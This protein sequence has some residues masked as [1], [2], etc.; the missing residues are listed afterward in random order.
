MTHTKQ[1]IPS[2]SNKTGQTL[3]IP[4]LSL[5]LMVGI[6]GSGKSTFAQQ[7]FESYEVVSSDQCRGIVSNNE[8]DLNATSDAF[9]LL[10]YTVS[11]RLKNGLLTVVDATNVQ[12]ESRSKLVRLAKEHHVLPV[13]VV[14]NVPLKTCEQRNNSREDRSIRKE[15]LRQQY[16]NLKR[17]VKR[18]KREGFRTIHVLDSEEKIANVEGFFREKRYNDLR[19]EQGPFNIIGDVHGCLEE[20]TELIDKLGYVR[21]EVEYDLINFGIKIKHPEG[22]RLIFVGDLVDRGPDSVGVLKLVMSTVKDEIAFCVPGNHDVKLR[23]KLIGKN[24][25]VNH[26]LEVTMAQLEGESSEFIKKIEQFVYGLTS[27]LIFDE[28]KLL[29]AHA[30]L[31]EAM[32]G[33]TSG[34]VRSFCL[35]GET[36]GETDEFGLPVRFDW[37]SEYR[38]TTKVVYG[39]T[40]VPRAEW[41]N[42]TMDIDTGCVF[43]GKLSALKYPEEEV[44]SIDA[45]KVYSEP[46]RP[47]EQAPIG[48][49]S[50][51]H[52]HDDLL[53]IEDVTGKRIIQTRLRN[54][55]T[56]KEENSISALEVM[57]RF[58]VNPKWLIY[59][60]PTMS[61]CET[62]TLDD[63]LEHPENAIDYYA[64]HNVGRIVLEEKHMGSRAIVIVC[65]DES[66]VQKRFGI[67]DEGIGICYTRTGRNFFS[68]SELEKAFLH[69][70]CKGLTKA[71]FWEKFN[72]DWV[73][74]D[75]ELMPWSAKAQALLKDQYAAVG[76]SATHGLSDVV[77]VLKKMTARNLGEEDDAIS[78]LTQSFIRKNEQAA[79][80]V[81]AYQGYC[82][83]VESLDDYQ[84]APF[85]ILATEEQTYS[86]KSHQ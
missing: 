37:A 67:E 25:N 27:H 84:L 10:N 33:R 22:R 46:K 16:L 55:I 6:S 60:P 80:F 58:A 68:D 56:I 70:V 50:T 65:K 11:K 30:G 64:K 20:L 32:H 72:T 74:L 39:H 66:V 14:L 52:Q 12:P 36:T 73:C 62:S 81:T 29:V 23:R 2:T 75:T 18:L 43:G 8:N 49:F 82:W 1:N 77:N 76:A 41:F 40:P 38:G 79:Q 34:A 63:Y 7:H 31:G 28:G 86:S 47:I 13:A 85:H 15:G 4:D 53:D 54:N 17:S 19:H 78:K 51:Q 9:E 35:Y 42:N 61:P 59:L 5:V 3:S 44:V 21:E 71:N 57:S 69:R 45:K 26:G 24:V 48:P 83:E